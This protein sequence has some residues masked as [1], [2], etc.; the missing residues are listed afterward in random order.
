MFR[1]LVMRCR[2]TRATALKLVLLVVVGV[3]GLPAYLAYAQSSSGGSQGRDLTNDPKFEEGARRAKERRERLDGQESKQ[4]RRASR[5][6]FRDLDR[7]EALSL[8]R[9]EFASELRGRLPDGAEPATGVKVKRRLGDLGA[10]VEDERTGERMLMRSTQPLLVEGS[11][12]EKEPLDLTLSDRGEQFAPQA[13]AVPVRIADASEAEISLPEADFSV[14]LDAPQDADPEV[15]DDRVFY[16]NTHTDA[17]AIVTPGVFGAEL[18][19]QMRSA[20]SPE[21]Y[22]LDVD[23]PEGAILRRARSKDPIADDPP[24][25]IEMTRADQTLGYIYPPNAYD[26]DGEPIPSS[27][28]L[29]GDRIVLDVKHR[30]LEIRYPAIV[31]PE[32]IQWGR[33]AGNYGDWPRWYWRQNLQGGP[34]GFGS[35]RNDPAYYYGL[36]QSMPTNSGFYNGAYAQWYFKAPPYTYVYRAIF[37]N[38]AH[39]PYASRAYQGIAEP[40]LTYWE[41]GVDMFNQYGQY[42]GNPGGPWGHA[43]SGYNHDFCYQPRCDR[44]RGPDQNT[45]VFGMEAYNPYGVIGTGSNRP[46]TTMGWADVYLG[47]R[48][49]PAKPRITAGPTSGEWFDD[50]NAAQTLNADT[51]DEGLGSYSLTLNGATS[52]GGPRYASCPYGVEN[53]TLACPRNLGAGWSYRLSQGTNYLS[54]SAQDVVGNNSVGAASFTRRVDRSNP[55]SVSLSGGL[56]T[57]AGKA[58]DSA[59]K[60]RV[61]GRDSYSGVRRL[62]LLVD[63]RSVESTMPGIQVA[64]QADTG[65]VGAS[66]DREL[67]F[68][69]VNLTEGPHRV[70]VRTTD[71]VNR[72]TDSTTIQVIVDRTGPA[73]TSVVHN[74]RPS[75]WTDDALAS[76][77]V[78]A[79]DLAAGQPDYGSGVRGFRLRRDGA[80]INQRGPDCDGTVASRCPRTFDAP[81]GYNAASRS[82]FPDDGIRRLSIEAYDALRTTPGETWDVKIDR[83]APELALSG[84]LAEREGQTVPPG[85]YQ[86]QI[87]ARDGTAGSPGTARSGATHIDVSVDGEQ[88]DVYDSQCPDGSCAISR[89]FAFDTADYSGGAHTVVVTADDAL[90]H[91]ASK[92]LKFTTDCCARPATGWGTSLPLD[93]VSYADFDGDSRADLLRVGPT[94]SLDVGLSDGSRFSAATRWGQVPV[95]ITP[96]TGDVDGDGDADLA[97][98]DA[99]SKRIQVSRSSGQAFAAAD[100]WGAWG[101][102]HDLRLADLDGDDL[103]DAVGVNSSS[104]GVQAAYS[105]GTRFATPES[106]ATTPADSELHLGDA[107]GDTNADLVIRDRQAG[108]VS[109]SLSDGGDLAAPTTWRTAIGSG[110]MKVGD[111]DGDGTADLAVADEASGRL[112]VAASDAASFGSF[113]EWGD[114]ARSTDQLGL[115][116]VN[117]NGQADALVRSTATGAISAALTSVIPPVRPE[118]AE[119]DD[120]SLPYDDTDLSD[121]LGQSPP[122]PPPGVFQSHTGPPPFMKLAWQDDAQIVG[123]GDRAPDASQE[124]FDRSVFRIEQARASIV[125]ISIYWGRWIKDGADPNDNYKQEI[126]TAISRLRG[127]GIGVYLTLS[128]NNYGDTLPATMTEP[129]RPS[130]QN[131]DPDAFAVFVRDVVSRYSPSVKLYALWNEPNLPGRANFLQVPCPAG[132]NAANNGVG[133]NTAALYR[134]LYF[135]GYAAAREASDT[136]S[137]PTARVHV[138]EFSDLPLRYARNDDC[139]STRKRKIN[140][141]KY[142]SDVVTGG[143]TP[144]Q[145]HGVAWH[146]YQHGADPDGS[147][148]GRVGIGDVGAMNS[149]VRDHFRAGKLRT[150]AAKVPRLLL[151]EFGY[152][153]RPQKPSA[154][155]R[156]WHS[157]AE[158]ADW[159]PRAISKGLNAKPAPAM[160]LLYKTAE[161]TPR[162]FPARGLS[163]VSNTT[164]S[165]DTGF[166]DPNS[167]AVRGTR[168]YGRGSTVR[169]AY[170]AVR[171]YAQR[172]RYRF[173]LGPQPIQPD[174]CP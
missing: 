75:G 15:L 121:V 26:A 148:E 166:M 118:V 34:H 72:S 139:N 1:A 84:P 61:I 8:A 83:E 68:D 80:T 4:R 41:G 94:G 82:D 113:R 11:G 6:K 145:T 29:D 21:Q 51:Y 30:G 76:V 174:Q 169:R 109:V 25:A 111:L 133:R 12:G 13:A 135:K 116:D 22:V 50:G 5:T 53:K 138:G 35:A 70:K 112:T 24:Q 96:A 89:S 54:V 71:G 95:G 90:G 125:R 140:T 106:W 67:D 7:R 74:A 114:G 126:D 32:V 85:T 49:P 120:P 142:M 132:S 137:G 20:D 136:L 157:E 17:D 162:N 172:K 43:Y 103:L 16:A 147:Q 36:Y 155:P 110:P 37:G 129:E 10:V 73:I 101:D 69:P 46:T 93:K 86:L 45:A 130:G 167:G 59:S 144:L 104:G 168:S 160:F 152:F 79:D 44:S 48:T 65:T 52:G 149:A 105:V 39:A 119:V 146:P 153:N 117:G 31:D 134:Q 28:T 18:F 164:G 163:D 128:G 62:E 14:R 92:T 151:T 91:S 40:N 81:L 19:V 99:I 141:L 63:E 123:G 97:F 98:V 55:S 56:A 159:L 3:S 58:V 108:T 161:E 87:S 156:D 38:V 42:A 124:Q 122:P 143:S 158:R 78:A 115:A 64:T 9:A 60:V 77:N 154:R 27:M 150:P 57:S 171:T 23:I 2:A 127:R 102:S 33:G 107:D 170:C 165:F 66:L 131:P 88:V 173:R 100:D 47:D